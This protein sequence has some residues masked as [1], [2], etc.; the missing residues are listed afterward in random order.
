[1]WRSERESSRQHARPRPTKKVVGPRPSRLAK[2][3]SDSPWPLALPFSREEW[4]KEMS[5][6]QLM[7]AY[8]DR[9]RRGSGG[10]TKAYV[11]L[12]Q[13]NGMS[14]LQ[15]KKGNPINIE[16]GNVTLSLQYIKNLVCLQYTE[17]ISWTN[18]EKK[19]WTNDEKCYAWTNNEFPTNQRVG[20]DFTWFSFFHPWLAK[21]EGGSWAPPLEKNS[22]PPPWPLKNSTH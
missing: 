5:I 2:A 22:N 4:R 15:W 7:F 9:S 17:C 14:S 13:N 20:A 21:Q 6:Y 19:S 3:D 1:M 12:A 11:Y 18:K 16:F 10:T 8:E